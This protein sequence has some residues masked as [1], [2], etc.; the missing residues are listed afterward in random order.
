MVGVAGDGLLGQFALA[1]EPGATLVPMKEIRP[2]GKGEP[3]YPSS[4][5]ITSLTIHPERTS[6][7]NGDNWPITWVDDGNQYTVYCNGEGFG[8][9]S[10]KGSR[11]QPRIPPKWTSEDGKTFHLLY[12]CF[13]KGPYQFNVQ[14]CSLELS[15]E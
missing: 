2:K 7:G 5:V 3:P 8:G 1:E 6:L 9:G 15:G 11:F 13:P 12:S 10:G 4:D 14:K